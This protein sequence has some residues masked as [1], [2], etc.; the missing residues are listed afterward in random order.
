MKFRF[1]T[2]SAVFLTMS[3]FSSAQPL[4][5]GAAA[6][7]V[8]APT[9]TG[10]PLAL[11]EV[12][13]A[14]TYTLVYFY[15]KADTPG[16]TAQGCS[17]R[18]AFEELTEKGVAVIGVSTDKPEA[19]AKFKAKYNLP[20]TLLADHDK[21]VVEAFGVPTTMGFAKRQAYLIKDGKIIWADHS[22]ST[23]QQ[24]ADVLKV[25]AAQ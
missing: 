12:Y 14:N 16:C 20:F 7:L 18:D 10:A 3:L 22:A 25:L 24:A 15:P 1:L 2:A 13:A 5:V 11:G 23:G 9:E 8:T 4:A 21:K 6:P 17:L 19:Q